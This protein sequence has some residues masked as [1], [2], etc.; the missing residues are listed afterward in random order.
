M[1]NA[2]IKQLVTSIPP[3]STYMVLAITYLYNYTTIEY[4]QQCIKIK[5]ENAY[6]ENLKRQN[7]I[8]YNTSSIIIILC[9][10]RKIVKKI[11]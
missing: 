4:K 11:C 8:N 7:S 1:I 9:A 10:L 5:R 2:F 3:L 6:K